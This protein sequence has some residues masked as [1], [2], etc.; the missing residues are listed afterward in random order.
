MIQCAPDYLVNDIFDICM[1]MIFNLDCRS[2][3]PCAVGSNVDDT[4]LENF[5]SAYQSE[6][7]DLIDSGRYDDRDDFTVVVQPFL[8]DITTPRNQVS[9]VVD[10]SDV[11]FGVLLF[12]VDYLFTLF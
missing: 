12:D 9:F 4:G 2:I 11:C 5:I 8:R 3:C 10:S 6:L 1:Y 7:R